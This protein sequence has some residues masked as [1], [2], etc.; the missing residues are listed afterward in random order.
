MSQMTEQISI[1]N[2]NG[3]IK[4]SDHLHK[5][6]EPTSRLLGEC[7]LTFMQDPQKAVMLLGTLKDV[8]T[9]SDVYN[10]GER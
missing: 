9:I 6:S 4:K 7:T 3:N 5:Q 2:G 10:L 8:L 1:G